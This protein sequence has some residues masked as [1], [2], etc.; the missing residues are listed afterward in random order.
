MQPGVYCLAAA[1][2]VYEQKVL[3]PVLPVRGLVA[4]SQ[5]S[6][7]RLW[8]LRGN[9]TYGAVDI[10][11]AGDGRPRIK[12]ARVHRSSIFDRH[13]IVTTRDGIPI[14]RRERTFI[15]YAAQAPAAAGRAVDTAIY[16]GLTTY[17]RLWL[18]LSRYS[19]PGCPGSA[20]VKEA[21]MKRHPFERPSESTLE[22][23]WIETLAAR[24]ITGLVRQYVVST[25]D[26]PKRID[27]A[28]PSCR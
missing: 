7:A 15:G 16:A 4:V 26:G 24:G 18:Y 28:A 21:L 20:A 14:T 19:G 3:A 25:V 11:I 12:N 17:D 1:R 10:T 2:V 5:R 6:A 23:E 27:L 8:C 22:D 9:A 13:D